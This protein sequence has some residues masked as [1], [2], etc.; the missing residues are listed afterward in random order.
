MTE[1]FEIHFEAT[2]PRLLEE[3]VEFETADDV[4]NLMKEEE[5]NDEMNI[6]FPVINLED[7]LKS[8]ISTKEEL[9]KIIKRME[10]KDYDWEKEPNNFTYQILVG[11]FKQEGEEIT[12]LGSRF[13]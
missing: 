11:V 9:V 10:E 13:A 3:G 7:A 4:W 6:G 2:I 5:K 1:Y 8:K 12:Y